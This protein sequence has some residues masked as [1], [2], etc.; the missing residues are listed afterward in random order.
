MGVLF[1]FDVE[2]AV[3]AIINIYNNPIAYG[4]DALKYF[5]PEVLKI[6]KENKY[7]KPLLKTYM[8][9]LYEAD[10]KT[11]LIIFY[12]QLWRSVEEEY[13]NRMEN[14]TK[15]GFNRKIITCYLITATRCKYNPNDR[16]FTLSLFV[17]PLAAIR[18]IGHEVFHLHFHE[19]F[20]DN[21]VNLIGRENTHM[22]KEAL[23]VLLNV[24]FKDLWFIEDKGYDS[25]KELREFI[26]KQWNEDKD[27]EKLLN[28]CIKFI[29]V[30]G[31]QR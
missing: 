15:R 13:I 23:T 12:S 21:I 9:E 18:N 28:S 7:P 25:H 27:F 4:S 20:F 2:V 3:E 17:N 29:L 11:P 31:G 16:S 14:I 1:K 8:L 19:H 26:V 24:E 5:E 6:L 30:K 22:L 10:I